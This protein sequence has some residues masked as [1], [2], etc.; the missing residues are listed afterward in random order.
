LPPVLQKFLGSIP[1]T[2]KVFVGF[3]PGKKSRVFTLLGRTMIHCGENQEN[4]EFT[5]GEPGEPGEL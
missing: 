5:V 3:C 2:G 1:A 4:P